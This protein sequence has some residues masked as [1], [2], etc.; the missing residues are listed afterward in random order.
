MNTPTLFD[1]LFVPPILSLL[2]E[3]TPRAKRKGSRSSHAGADRSAGTRQRVLDAVYQIVKDCGPLNGNEINAVYL[4]RA[5]GEG[6]PAV[7]FDTPR[8]RAGEL[9]ADNILVITNPDDF[10]NHIYDLPAMERAA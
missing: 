1:D 9:A 7:H 3:D 10:R 8:K 4:R 6:W 5:G 2:G